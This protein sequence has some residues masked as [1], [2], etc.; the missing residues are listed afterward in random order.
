[1]IANGFLAENDQF[2][3]SA[4]SE[5]NANKFAGKTDISMGKYQFYVLQRAK[6]LNAIEIQDR[7]KKKQAESNTNS[8]AQAQLN[9]H[10]FYNFQHM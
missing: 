2:R 5:W 7:E 9:E 10:I 6:I 8:G 3:F 1:M 4:A